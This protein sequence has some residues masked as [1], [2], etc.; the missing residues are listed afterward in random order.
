MLQAL[1]PARAVAARTVTGGP[2]P[3]SVRREIARVEAELTSLGFE[4]VSALRSVPERA[5]APACVPPSAVR[6]GSSVVESVTFGLSASSG[7][8]LRIVVEVAR[9]AR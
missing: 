6:S 5:D 2:A 1:D 9:R 8:R 4:V 7:P 3:E